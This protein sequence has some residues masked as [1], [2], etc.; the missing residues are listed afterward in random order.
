[1]K[2]KKLIKRAFVKIQKNLLQYGIEYQNSSFNS[3]LKL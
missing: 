1:M 3:R 2:L